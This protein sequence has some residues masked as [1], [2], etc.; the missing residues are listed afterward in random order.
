MSLEGLQLGKYRLSRLIGSGGMGD[1][2]IGE[3][4]GI[5]RQVAVKVMRAEPSS[6]PDE[7][8]LKHGER[9]FQREM[10][11]IAMLD[12][13]HILPLYDYG[14][15]LLYKTT[16][17]YMVMPFRQEGSLADWL[18]QRAGLL[19]LQEVVYFLSQAAEALQHAH[20]HQIIHQDVKPSNFLI[21]RKRASASLPDLLL[22]DF[23]IARISSLTSSVSHSSRGTPT[24]MAPEQW[25]GDPVPAT[26]QYALAIMTYELLTGRPPFRG[27]PEQM[28]FM[29]LSTPPPAPSTFQATLSAGINAVIL[30][31]LSKK[32]EERFSTISDFVAAFQQAIQR[33]GDLHAT[34]A[35]SSVE[36][37]TGTMR[38]LTLPGGRKARVTVPQGIQEGQVLS[39]EG[40][41]EPYY[42]E[43]PRGQLILTV[44]IAPVEKTIFAQEAPY[45]KTIAASHVSTP[46]LVD[47]ASMGERTPSLEIPRKNVIAQ[48]AQKTKDDYQ[49]EGDKL[50]SMRRYQQAL[51]AYEEGLRL[52]PDDPTLRSKCEKLCK[53]LLIAPAK[54]LPR[55]ISPSAG[56]FASAAVVSEDNE[57]DQKTKNQWLAEGDKLYST[58]RYQ[59]ALAAY[60][61]GL[62]LAPD[63]STLRRKYNNTRDYLKSSQ[64]YGNTQQPLKSTAQ[65]SDVPTYENSRKTTRIVVGLIVIVLL[66]LI[67]NIL[68]VWNAT[69]VGLTLFTG[70]TT[71]IAII[72]G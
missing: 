61:K 53:Y 64:R 36:A 67:I 32:P 8:A 24:Y 30:R 14:E 39:L 62:Q 72:V 63:D 7:D 35:I 46:Q 5:G 49:D 69:V 58:R 37:S 28:M 27:R 50:Y 6:Y 25:S 71:L 68:T 45:E 54:Q 51:K 2:Y 56:S 34:L 47:K 13:P 66:F 40:L 11:A 26:D 55:T 9:L 22:A 16:L 19:S 43:G 1:V 52:A 17:M 57:L 20:D 59:Q 33:Q 23:G 65:Q 18:R 3:D 41:G 42:D 38:E 60:E 44:T 10:R 15:E 48:P 21:R 4:A 29:H 12:H 31:A 70:I